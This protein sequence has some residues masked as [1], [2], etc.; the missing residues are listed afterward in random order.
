MLR[1]AKNEVERLTRG[2]FA[3]KN[4][5]TQEI[6]DGVTIEGRHKR[7]KQF[8][9]TVAPWTE[10]KKDRVGIYAL[11]KF[12]GGLLYTHISSEFPD[13]VKDIE[14]LRLSTQEELELL[15]P[16]RQTAADQRRF[17]TRIATTYQYDVGNAL[18]GNYGPDLEVDSPLK[19][20][21]LIRKLNDKFAESMARKG[22]AKVFRTV[23]GQIDQEFARSSCDKQDI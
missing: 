17:L 16:P 20:R 22:H 11:K 5:S 4:R 1:I 7:E 15:G 18:S 13:V 14:D 12:L 6:K 3:V 23:Q 2:W 8:F 9:S 10:L 19:L 21:T